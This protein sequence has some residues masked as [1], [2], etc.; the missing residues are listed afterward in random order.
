MIRKR[1]GRLARSLRRTSSRNL[2]G[3]FY[4]GLSVFAVLGLGWGIYRA[5]VFAH[6]TERLEI[7]K[8]SVSGIRRISENEILAH[9]GYGPGMSVLSVDLDEMRRAIEDVLWVRHARVQRVWPDEIVISVVEREPITL[10]RIDGEIYQVDIE[11]VVLAPDLLSESSSPILDGLH[12]GDIDGNETKIKL[13]QKTIETI[14]KSEL[15]EVHIAESGD[16][17]VVPINNPILIDLGSSEHRDRWERYVQLKERIHKDYP[18]AFRVDLRFRDQVIIQT[19]ESEPAR[20]V[21]WG[22]ETKLL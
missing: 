1:V 16:V 9:A 18:H 22:E 20:N 11:G 17:S 12:S 21:I 15:S 2:L 7:R 5:M 3:Y 10:A 6:N 4:V 19:E 13:Y 8:I 14:G